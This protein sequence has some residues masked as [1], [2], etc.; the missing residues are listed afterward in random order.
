MAHLQ[1]RWYRTVPD[2]AR[3]GKTKR[4]P[5]PRHG[6]GRRYKARLI[7]PDGN[8]ISKTFADGQQKIA[9]AWLATQEVDLAAGSFIDPAPGR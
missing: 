4:V 3:P 6:V 2:P 1:D 8:E 7:G 9:R 5:T